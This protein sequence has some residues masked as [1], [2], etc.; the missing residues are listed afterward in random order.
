LDVFVEGH[1]IVKEIAARTAAAQSM[2]KLFNDMQ[3]ESQ[4]LGVPAE[5]RDMYDARKRYEN[6]LAKI[7]EA[8]RQASQV[9][10][11]QGLKEEVKYLDQR[12]EALKLFQLTL[13]EIDSKKKIK[14]KKVETMEALNAYL[15]EVRDRAAG[16]DEVT[17]AL[18][19]LENQLGLNSEEARKFRDVLEQIKKYEDQIDEKTKLDREKVIQAR[20]GEAE[21]FQSQN[22]N[23]AGLRDSAK[24]E[25]VPIL[26]EMLSIQRKA[27]N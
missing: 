24:D 11:E 2:R 16:V 8:E 15:G 10:N 18:I 9:Q 17:I 26:R 12:N 1:D 4:R 13:A 20:S 5:Q 19:K 27:F 22:I 6:T 25:S 23:L 21:I 7:A 3:Q 14:D